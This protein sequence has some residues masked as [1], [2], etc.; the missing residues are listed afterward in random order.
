MTSS[1]QVRGQARRILVAEDDEST[2][3]VLVEALKAD[4]F[5]VVE[6]TDGRELFWS[7]EQAARSHPFDLVVADIQMPV[8]S[9]LDVVE[10]WRATNGPK[11]LLITAFADADVRRRTESLKVTL[12]GKPFELG[13]LTRLIHEM[14]GD[15][16]AK[17]RP[18]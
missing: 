3:L 7:V 12:L 16:K 13:E 4:G 15:S 8:Y 11:V 14:L 6:A 18:A 17:S 10:A 2:R 1:V 5:E 9:A